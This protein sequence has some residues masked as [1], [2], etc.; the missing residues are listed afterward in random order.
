MPDTRPVAAKRLGSVLNPVI[1]ILAALLKDHPTALSLGQG[2][3]SWGPPDAVRDCLRDACRNASGCDQYGAVEG[4][5]ELLQ[6]LREKLAGIERIDLEGSALIVTAGSNMAFHAIAQ[7]IC[8]P[9]SEVIVPTPYYFNHVMAI[10]LA[11]GQPVAVDAGILPDPDQLAAAITERTR[12]IVTISPG[13]PSGAVL[14]EERLKAINQLCARYGLFHLHDEAYMGFCHGEIPHWSPGSL[15]GSGHH[16]VTLR[17]FSKSHGMA[18]WRLGYMAAPQQIRPALA[19]VQD[20]IAICPSRPMQRAA[21]AAVNVPDN[22]VKDKVMTLQAKR[23]RMQELFRCNDSPWR[24]LGPCDGALYGLVGLDAAG[25]SA[26][27]AAGASDQ[28]QGCAELMQVLVRRF[29]VGVLSG[30]SFG[31]AASSF[32]ISYGMLEE[33]AFEQAMQRLL[34]GLNTLAAS[35]HLH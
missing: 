24:L 30:Q 33:Q 13:N 32:R 10:Q 20:T 9:G 31:L 35:L 28:E 22:W 26:R 21:L 5:Q 4:D 12:A 8:D 34:K 14:P 23:L 25:A 18:G 29:G 1:P 2:M 3:V 16:T 6:A 15:S 17:S 19:K 7:V 27:T 11:G